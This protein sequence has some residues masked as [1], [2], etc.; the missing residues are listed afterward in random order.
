MLRA[1]GTHGDPNKLR[2]HRRVLDSSAPSFWRAAFR[3]RGRSVAITSSIAIGIG[4]VWT[5]GSRTGLAAIGISLAIAAFETIRAE[6]FDVKRLAKFGAGAAA[7]LPWWSSS[8]CRAHLRTPWYA[9]GSPFG[10]L[11]LRGRSRHRQQCQRAIVGT[12]W[13]WRGR[14]RDGEG[15]SGRRRRRRYRST[16][17]VHDFGSLR[18][19]Q[20][21]PP[22][23]DNAQ[24]W[25]RHL[26]AELGMLGT[27]PA[28][29]VV[30]GCLRR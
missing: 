5:S 23:A 30:R 20:L 13:L 3:R 11:P 25:L 6:R 1:A 8:S 21:P 4:A 26:V 22:S 16:H 27:I 14:D 17:Y 18:G 10:Y 2:R 19:Y 15:T 9:G 12:V 7:G 24:A 29:V 28:A